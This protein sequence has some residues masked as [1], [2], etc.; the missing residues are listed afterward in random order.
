MTA[1]GPLPLVKTGTLAEPPCTEWG[2]SDAVQAAGPPLK[3]GRKV[4]PW[5]DKA[6]G[7]KGNVSARRHLHTFYFSCQAIAQQ[8]K[9]PT[10]K[11]VAESG[12]PR[13]TIAI[14]L[15]SP[16]QDLGHH[17][18]GPKFHSEGRL[19]TSGPLLPLAKG[20][21]L[22]GRRQWENFCLLHSL[23]HGAHSPTWL[24]KGHLLKSFPESLI[25]TTRCP[26]FWKVCGSQGRRGKEGGMEGRERWD[27]DEGV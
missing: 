21:L 12:V 27:P 20:V 23:G 17:P 16:Q 2:R 6:K 4:P 11:P 9:I 24:W 5:Q 26:I 14:E 22:V 18:A 10:A 8:T 19:L 15:P 1:R 3:A 25:S 7:N 13:A